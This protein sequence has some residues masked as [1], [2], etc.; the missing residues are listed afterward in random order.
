MVKGFSKV[1]LMGNLT[2]DPETRTTSTGKSVT[3][4]SVAV[5]RSYRG[6]SGNNVEEVSYIECVAW[7]GT[8]ETIARYMHRGSAIMLSGRLSQRSWDDEK[9]GTKRSRVEVIVEEFNFIGGRDD[10]SYM[11][12]MPAPSYSSSKVGKKSTETKADADTKSGASAD[13]DVLPDEV[14]V[15]G[16]AEIDLQGV[17]F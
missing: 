12:E 10:D 3:S 15:S 6:A 2:R 14:E 13:E 5:N 11:D 4:F 9:T 1:V 17:P 7:N 16:D 8:G